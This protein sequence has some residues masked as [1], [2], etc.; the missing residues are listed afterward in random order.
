MQD[1]IEEGIRL[2]RPFYPNDGKADLRYR[3]QGLRAERYRRGRWPSPDELAID[4]VWREA[5]D[6]NAAWDDGAAA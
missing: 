1:E 6:A 2:L 3:V 5:W 4:A